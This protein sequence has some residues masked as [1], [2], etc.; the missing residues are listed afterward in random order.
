MHC[1]GAHLVVQAAHAVMVLLDEQHDVLAQAADAHCT[2][3]QQT[4]QQHQQ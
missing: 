4:Q 2:Q 1:E 3:Q